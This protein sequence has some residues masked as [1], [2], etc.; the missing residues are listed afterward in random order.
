MADSFLQ[1]I[2]EDAIM[3]M[4]EDGIVSPKVIDIYYPESEWVGIERYHRLRLRK[5]GKIGIIKDR[6]P[7]IRLQALGIAVNLYPEPENPESVH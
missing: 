4:A 1:E 3:S 6:Y 7:F 5:D 2:V